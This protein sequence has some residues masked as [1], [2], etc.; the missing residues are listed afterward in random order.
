M[1][2]L[3]PLIDLTGRVQRVLGVGIG[4]SYLW[5][6][7]KSILCAHEPLNFEFWI[8]AHTCICG[9]NH[10]VSHIVREL[11]WKRGTCFRTKL[12]IDIISIHMLNMYWCPT[13]CGKHRHLT[14]ALQRPN[15]LFAQP[16][17]SQQRFTQRCL[18]RG[19]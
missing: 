8:P 11:A 12:I 6:G 4:F 9:E 7:H 1:A 18:Q 19:M 5:A 3:V 10:T 2:Q 16:Q 17:S 13:V 15:L 14:F